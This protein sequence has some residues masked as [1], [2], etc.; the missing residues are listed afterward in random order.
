MPSALQVLDD[1]NH[2]DAKQGINGNR[3]AGSLYDLI[4]A[5]KNKPLKPVG[6][7]N[8]VR[9]IKKGTHIE[10]WLNGVKVLEFDQGSPELKA[11][12]AQSKFRDK[13]GFG[14]AQKGHILLQDH[15]DAVWYRNIKIRELK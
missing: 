11:A 2:P 12:I 10:H 4:P 1:D 7:Y 15:G 9:L 3:T 14:E 8:H 5:A 6:E 13:P